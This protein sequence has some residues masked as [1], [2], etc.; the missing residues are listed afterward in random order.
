MGVELA[1]ST[2]A[3]GPASL[4]SRLDEL[5]DEQLTDGSTLLALSGGRGR[6]A[7]EATLLF[8]DAY[9]TDSGWTS[10]E[11]DDDPE[12]V[13]QLE[14]SCP[15]DD[16]LEAG[17]AGLDWRF[18][19]RDDA[20]AAVCGAGFDEWERIL[21]HLGVLTVPSARRHGW[22]TRA[23]AVATNEALDRGLV[24]QWRARRSNAASRATAMRLG[25]VAL[26]R[27]TTVLLP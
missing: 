8:T 17:L 12:A 13:G 23:A 15:P 4:Q 26:G 18:A 9:V 21:A 3:V 19:V 27:Q 11:V 22:A 16:V 10:V 2:I 20:D 24:P 1:G 7:G 25:Y 6:L 5:S 14:R